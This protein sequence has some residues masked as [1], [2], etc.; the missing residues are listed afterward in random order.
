[1]HDVREDQ[2]KHLTILELILCNLLASC[3]PRP[4]DMAAVVSRVCNG[5]QTQELSQYKIFLALEPT[6]TP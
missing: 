3:E 4:L 2:R 1:M 5:N 6:L